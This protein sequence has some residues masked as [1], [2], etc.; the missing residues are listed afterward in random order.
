MLEAEAKESGC[1]PPATQLVE[2][3]Q[4]FADNAEAL[5][6]KGQEKEIENL[7]RDSLGNAENRMLR[8][9]ED[10]GKKDLFDVTQKS[11]W[12]EY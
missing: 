5:S 6:G 9:M 7:S 1:V 11:C 10:G 12:R 3:R 4:T 2:G 8:K